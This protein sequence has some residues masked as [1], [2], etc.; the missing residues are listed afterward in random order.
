MIFVTGAT[1]L[2]GSYLIHALLQKGRK[3]RALLYNRNSLDRTRRIFESLGS[4]AEALIDKVEWIQGDVLDV[5]ILEE[6]MKNIEQVFHCAAIVSFDP[7]DKNLMMKINVE[8]TTNVVNTALEAGVKKL[9]HVSSIAA[10]GRTDDTNVIDENSEWRNTSYN[11]RYSKSKYMAE[12][13]VWRASAEGLPVI[14]VNPSIILGYGHPK[15]GSTRMFSTIYRMPWFYGKGTNGYVDVE[16]VVSVMIALMDSDIENERFVVSAG[17]FSY[18]EIFSLIAKGF[19]KPLPRIEVPDLILNTVWRF[20]AI[21]SALTKDKPLITKET[22]TTSKSR[23]LY[24][25]DKLIKTIGYKYKPMEQTIST[26]CGMM[27]KEL[28][29]A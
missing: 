3:V 1:G 29:K 27:K 9:C 18:R 15:K 19:N 20:E 12:R 5:A 28:E 10:L 11:S 25:S 8:G 13:E 26:L 7:S 14:I 23:Y 6:A 17:N 24:S 16:D 4:D 2:V 21:R 22:A